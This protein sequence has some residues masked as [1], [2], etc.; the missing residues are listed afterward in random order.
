MADAEV[1]TEEAAV[2]DVAL[3]AEA[4][5][6]IVE[7]IETEIMTTESF[8]TAGIFDDVVTSPSYTTQGETRDLMLT[9]SSNHSVCAFTFYTLSH[10]I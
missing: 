10:A 7:E 3:A 4:E 2:E 5:E 8:I 9:I 1:T 6:E